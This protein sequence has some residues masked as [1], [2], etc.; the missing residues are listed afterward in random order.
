MKKIACMA[1]ALMML[2]CAGALADSYTQDSTEDPQTVV[3]TTIDE[4]YTIVIPPRVTL[5]F[6]AASTNLPVEVTELRL[7]LPADPNA[8]VRRL[9]VRPVND[10]ETLVNTGDASQTIAFTFDGFQSVGTLSN[11]LLFDETETQNIAINISEDEW[12][13]AAAGSYERT[14]TFTVAI[15]SFSAASVNG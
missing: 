3:T 4:E 14:L 6:E 10:S 7:G 2:I 11:V 12:N 15:A 1:L 5:P 9:Y 13:Q 8:Q